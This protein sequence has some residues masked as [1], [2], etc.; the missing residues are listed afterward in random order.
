MAEVYFSGGSSSAALMYEPMSRELSDWIEDNN[1][2][3]YR[4]LSDRAR[5]FFDTASRFRERISWSRASSIRE[6]ADSAL[7]AIYIED[8]FRLLDDLIQIQTAKSRMRRYIMASPMVRTL[9]R[10]KRLSGWDQSVH[11]DPAIPV[12]QTA[13]YRHATNGVLV[14]DSVHRYYDYE[15]EIYN[16]YEP[17]TVSEKADILLTWET[18]ESI[19]KIDRL[20][21]TSEYGATLD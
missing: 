17:M 1:D 13:E 11:D 14:D 18:V 21:P 12:T 15:M 19:I 6:Q 3:I 9:Y 16:E 5:A 10:N 20:D 7:N 2:R 4:R 8:D